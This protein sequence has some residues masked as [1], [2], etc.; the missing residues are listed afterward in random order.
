MNIGGGANGKSTFLEV[1]QC[2]L[3][4]YNVSNVSI[5]ALQVDRFVKA[6]L[7]G[8]LANIYADISSSD[9]KETDVLKML[10]TGE[11]IDVEKKNLD[12]YSMKN[13]AKLFFSA[14]K[15]P[16]VADQSI[17]FFRRFIIIQWLQNFTGRANTNLRREL[18][19]ESDIRI[20]KLRYHKITIYTERN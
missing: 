4:E 5:H 14:N 13:T 15:F 16:E 20:I 7:D 1:L 11:N 17:G 19:E 18:V 6:R 3:G 2:F 12:G 8:K 10:I 9:L